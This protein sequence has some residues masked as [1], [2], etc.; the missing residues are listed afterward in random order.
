M[1][2]IKLHRRY[3]YHERGEY[4]AAA[5]S[6]EDCIKCTEKVQKM[7]SEQKVEDLRVA[8]EREIGQRKIQDLNKANQEEKSKTIASLIISIL[9]LILLLISYN[10]FRLQRKRNKM[11]KE[12]NKVRDK[13]FSIISHDLKA[14]A[15]A[16]KVAIENIIPGIAS[17]KHDD[18]LSFCTILYENTENQIGVIE[19]L[20][21][22]TRLQTNKLQYLP[23]AVDIVPIIRDEI[24]LYQISASQKS[25]KWQQE[26]PPFCIVH[27][28][29]Q[30]ISIV[31]RNLINN[32]VKFTNEGGNLRV[33]CRIESNEAIVSISDNG[34]GMT[35]EQ[36]DALYTKEQNVK[37]R[38]GTKGEKGTGLGLI[39][40]KDLL[41]RN[42]SRLLIK[43]ET[44]KGTTIQFRLKKL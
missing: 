38:F 28:D 20:M 2:T 14:P 26:L 33:S 23:K 31:I 37:V 43:S 44:G 13:I 10:L 21:H 4:Q 18:F 34:I 36:I 32:A 11:L 7:R 5:Q 6:W 39:L 15:I 17:L 3:F 8:F 9:L 41:E 35:E 29:R 19:N 16:Q 1:L 42:H 12:S 24:K 30:M 40:C 25:I 22:W 27:V